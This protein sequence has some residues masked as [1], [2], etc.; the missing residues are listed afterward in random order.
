MISAV[1]VA[2]TTVS[3]A[4]SLRAQSYNKIADEA[5][6]AG[7]AYAYSCLK[8]SG[9]NYWTNPLKPNTSCTGGNNGGSAYLSD[10]AATSESPHYRS[11]F[12]VSIPDGSN[13][14]TVEGKVELVA[15][16]ATVTKTW[17]S[18]KVVVINIA[19]GSS[20][21]VTQISAGNDHA[22]AVIQGKAY[23]WGR[24]NYGQLGNN[25]TTDSSVPIPV[26]AGGVLSGKTITAI[27]AGGVDSTCAVAD[28]K[29]YCWGNNSLGQLGDGTTVE[30]HVPVAVNTSG[31]LSG[32]TVTDVGH[33]YHHTCALASGSV[34]CWG[35]GASGQLGNG[36]TSN[37]SIPVAVNTSGV[38]SGKSVT[39]IAVSNSTTCALANGQDYC[40]GWNNNGQLGNNSTASSSVP[41]AVYT[42]G[43]LSGK[44]VTA[45]SLGGNHGC[46]VAS[47]QAYC[48]GWNA[49]GQLGNNAV[50]NS[51][52]PVAVNTSGVLSGKTVTS[53]GDKG[54]ADTCAIANGK[55]Y[56]WGHNGRGKLGNN[57]TTNSSVPVAVDTS[58]VLNNKVIDSIT[59]GNWNCAIA[60]GQAYCWGRNDWGQLGNNSTTDSHVPVA[61]SAPS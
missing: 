56:C 14:S 30:R 24:N 33:D 19:G 32:K 53:L 29:V 27:V 12:S 43:V 16:D 54:D 10:E 26:Y 23:C 25:L 61:V 18:N 45:I 36:T 5:A 46:A 22:C 40:W 37:S 60:S 4:T 6:Q 48:W 42:G 15:A 21:G 17:V 8:K 31:V 41:V 3:I 11:S 13:H 1:S 50:T 2:Q 20:G 7:V 9:T 51:S 55:V 52:I 44:T 47:G 57:S 35:L 49:Y 28:G 39:A 38:L 59:T 58:G 34:Y